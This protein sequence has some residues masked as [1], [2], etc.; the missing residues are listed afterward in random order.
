MN[1]IIGPDPNGTNLKNNIIMQ[2]LHDN[3]LLVSLAVENF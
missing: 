1:K 3:V 2:Q